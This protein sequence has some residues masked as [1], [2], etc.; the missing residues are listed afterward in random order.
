MCFNSRINLIQETEKWAGIR[1][2]PFKIAE[3][4]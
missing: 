3:R 1:Y 4:S 2:S